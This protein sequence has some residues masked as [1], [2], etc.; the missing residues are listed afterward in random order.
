MITLVFLLVILLGYIVIRGARYLI[1]I[2]DQRDIAVS[3]LEECHE[4]LV[5]WISEFDDSEDPDDQQYVNGLR[6]GADRIRS[7]LNDIEDEFDN[8]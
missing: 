3:M 4:D 5:D 7:T 8:V 1:K 2:E 6:E